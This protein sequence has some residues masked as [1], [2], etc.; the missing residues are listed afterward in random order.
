MAEDEVVD[1][2]RNP[3]RDPNKVVQEPMFVLVSMTDD[4]RLV[5][6]GPYDTFQGAFE[7]AERLNKHWEG[8]WPGGWSVMPQSVISYN[9]PWSDDNPITVVPGESPE[10]AI[11]CPVCDAQPGEKCKNVET[12]EEREHSHNGRKEAWAAAELD[13]KGVFTIY[14]D[15]YANDSGTTPL[16]SPIGP[17]DSR[18]DARLFMWKMR[19]LW[20]SWE[21]RPLYT[22]D[23]LA[24][25][26]G[27]QTATQ[28]LHDKEKRGR[29]AQAPSEA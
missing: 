16:P 22:P 17:F 11:A 24:E 20:G 7:T 13:L 19:P 28:F 4:L 10:Y 8:L 6:K 5:K 1:E 12:S 18:E 2:L 15:I 9:V 3:V 27:R 14:G 25:V 29:H 26:I 21:I 23:E